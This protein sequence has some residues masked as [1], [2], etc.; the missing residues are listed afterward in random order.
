M[1]LT[2]VEKVISQNA[3]AQVTAGNVAVC[4][5]DTIMIHDG[6]GILTL[7]EFSR[8][9]QNG[10]SL[11]NPEKTLVVLDH[12]GPCSRIELASA[13]I[14]LRQFARENNAVL[15]EVGEGICHQIL[16]E[17]WA[18]P[19]IIV[20]GADSHTTTSGAMGALGTGM[21]STDVAVAMALGK[22]WFKVPE[23]IMVNLSGKLPKGVYA[24]DIILN[25]AKILG[26]DGAT[27]KV[28]EFS[29]S[30][31]GEMGM[32]ERFTMSNMAIELGAK[33]GMF[34]SDEITKSYLKGQ[35]REKDWVSLYPDSDAQYEKEININLEELE[36][37]VAK[38][39]SVDNV[40]SISEI[41]GK[42]VEQIFLG[43]CTNGR[44]E[45]LAVAAKIIRGKRI[46]ESTRMYVMPASVQVYKDA[47]KAGYISDFI[48]FGAVVL[49]T[50]CGPCSGVH[51]GLLGEGENCLST[52]NR[53][54]K[55]RMG[56]PKSFV[57]LASPAVAASS[58]LTGVISDPR[59]V[60]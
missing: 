31:I 8:L 24:K 47:L 50:G 3:G 56:S 6:T 14:R 37:M 55:G 30:G 51:L 40:C 15:Y 7:D 48:D 19:G 13:H 41:K 25:L 23:T 32:S 12:T 39:H 17:R 2:L 43:S 27:Y 53:N 18:K 9:E 1:G 11:T 46:A 33:S 5:V 36:P 16:I 21:G 35:N 4:S 22:N 20:L 60:M 49:P 45:D 42:P 54:F 10:L 29:G 59:E 52:T 28:L 44:L 57:Y 26:S 34:P 38:P 58:A